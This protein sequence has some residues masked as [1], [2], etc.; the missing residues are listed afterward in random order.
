MAEDLARAS[1]GPAVE[2]RGGK[3]RE[4]LVA[5][6]LARS[7]ASDSRRLSPSRRASASRWRRA[8]RPHELYESFTLASYTEHLRTALAAGWRFVGSDELETAE[9]PLWC[10]AMTSTTR[11]LRRWK[12]HTSRP[13]SG[14]WPRTACTSAASGTRR[15]PP[16]RVDTTDPLCGPSARPHVSTRARSRTTTRW[17]PRWHV[18]LE[19]RAI[20]SIS[21]SRPSPTCLAGGPVGS[22]ELSDG[23]VEHLRAP[24]L[25]RDRICLGLE[26]GLARH[27]PWKPVLR[28]LG[29]SS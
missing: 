28:H 8:P 6:E 17:R 11:R 27:E 5:G 14:L 23:L 21:T 19:P 26:P 4:G 24:F 13:G 2:P 18:T 22:I 1:P 29:S 15:M 9:P 7:S 20:C 3:G 12:W 25:R 16:H 10:F